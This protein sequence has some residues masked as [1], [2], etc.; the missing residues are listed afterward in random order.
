MPLL[1][2]S[3]T[4]FVRNSSLRI[5]RRL[6]VFDQTSTTPQQVGLVKRVYVRPNEQPRPPREHD[7]P[8]LP[9]PNLRRANTYAPEGGPHSR[10]PAGHLHER[11]LSPSYHQGHHDP[12]RKSQSFAYGG[13]KAMT[14]NGPLSPTTRNN[15]FFTFEEAG[16][17]PLP[18][19]APQLC[20]SRINFCSQQNTP[21]AQ[22]KPPTQRKKTPPS[23][24]LVSQ[25]S[26]LPNQKDSFK[27]RFLRR[28]LS[29][30]PR[31]SQHT[32]EEQ[33]KLNSDSSKD[34][35]SSNSGGISWSQILARL[36]GRSL[37]P[38]P[39]RTAPP[40]DPKTYRRERHPSDTPPSTGFRRYGSLPMQKTHPVPSTDVY[41]QPRVVSDLAAVRERLSRSASVRL[42]R[43]KV[44]DDRDNGD[45][46]AIRYG[47]S[48]IRRPHQQTG[49]TN[50]IK[51]STNSD[52]PM[53]IW[54]SG[55][56]LA[57][58]AGTLTVLSRAQDSNYSHEDQPGSHLSST[59]RGRYERSQSFVTDSTQDPMVSNSSYFQFCN[60]LMVVTVK[61]FF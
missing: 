47:H 49:G 13:H 34:S 27:S 36:H 42:P 29:P 37:T 39:H 8:P 31:E 32:E 60:F 2:P 19:E 11:P 17:R 33:N 52:M 46:S 45:R 54:K 58:D 15:N 56:S 44:V 55:T 6:K 5:S 25:D 16:S 26:T 23:S 7:R 14:S 59:V 12:V 30:T 48:P 18:H 4:P 57:T 22:S 35:Q 40:A 28:P 21:H 43:A 38:S 41:L 1:Q 51:I 20:N 3:P 9:P 24:L 61:V 53:K 10:V 50:D